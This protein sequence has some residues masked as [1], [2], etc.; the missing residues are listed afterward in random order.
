M[1][2]LIQQLDPGKLVL[3]ETV[4]LTTYLLVMSFMTVIL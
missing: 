4:G 3:A 2:D 1:T